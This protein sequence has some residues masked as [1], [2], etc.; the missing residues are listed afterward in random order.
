M[1]TPLLPLEILARNH[2]ILC[3]TG[4]L[5]IL[6]IG[7]LVARYTR[8]L[9]YKWFYAH[10]IIQLVIAGPV[11]GVG[12]S[13]GYKTTVMLEQGHFV[14]PHQKIGLSLI[15]LY[16]LQII[17]GGLV[18]FFKFPTLFRG[19]RAPHNYF[20]VVFGLAIFI[21]AQYNVHYALFI[22]WDLR[23]GGL[24]QIP[25]SATNAWMAGVI[26]FWILY[27]LGMT[28]IPRQ[29]KQERERRNIV[30]PSHDQV[31]LKPIGSEQ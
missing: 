20:H 1:S 18:H 12:W 19:Y 22:E 13:F 14:D 30:Y 16:V 27:G 31:H 15:I 2:G 6:P 8:T 21:L 24:H 28:L 29:F 10:W 4:F 11:I 5:V 23:T 9:P 26:L 17:I 25:Q 3:A 7:V